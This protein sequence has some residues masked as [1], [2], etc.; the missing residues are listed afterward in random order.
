MKK[1]PFIE[2]LIVL[3]IAAVAV[4]DVVGLIRTRR[5]TYKSAEG[6][7]IVTAPAQTKIGD[8]YIVNWY[9]YAPE[10]SADS[11]TMGGTDELFGP[12]GEK[13]F[14]LEAD[15]VH[16]GIRSFYVSCYWGGKSESVQVQIKAVE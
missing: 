8:I 3:L 6:H 15:M 12:E 4:V 1:I 13:Y 9:G 14:T 2:I 5:I 11:C 16:V 7:L 10:G